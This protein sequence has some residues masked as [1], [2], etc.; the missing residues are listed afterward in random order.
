[1]N[2][3]PKRNRA[4]RGICESLSTNQYCSTYFWVM[5]LTDFHCFQQFLGFSSRSRAVLLL[6]LRSRW[7]W[8]I[9]TGRSRS[10]TNEEEKRRGRGVAVL[11]TSTEFIQWTF[12]HHENHSKLHLFWTTN[13]QKQLG[14]FWLNCYIFILIIPADDRPEKFIFSWQHKKWNAVL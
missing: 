11:S 7:C 1:M 10:E 9:S 5:V 4:Q 14:L 6:L 2:C 12:T 3:T 8:S 13:A